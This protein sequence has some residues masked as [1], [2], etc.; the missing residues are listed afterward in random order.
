MNT[1]SARILTRPIDE[2]ALQ[3][4]QQAGVP[5][6]LARLCAARRVL[7]ADELDDALAGLLPHTDLKNCDKAAE[8]LARAVQ[9]RE[10]ILIVADYD[11]DGATACAAGVAGLRAMGGMADFLVP[12]RFEDGYGLTPKI[13]Q[14]AAG[15]GA[16]LLMTVDNGMAGAEGVEKAKSLGMDV[17]ITDHHLPADTD[18]DCIIVNPNQRG[19]GFASKSLAGVGVIFYVLAAL[20]ARLRL[21]G[22]FAGGRTEPN[23]GGLL[24]LVALGT[25]ADVV[26]L[27]RNNRILVAQGLKRIRAGKVCPG[28]LALFEAAGRDWRKAQPLD[29]GFALGPRINAA[30]RLDDMSVGINCLLAQDPGEARRLAAQL[31]NLNSERREIEQ[32]MLQ[33]AL[34]DFSD[35]PADEKKTIVAYRE[36]FHQGVVGIVAGRLK[37][38]FYRPVIVFAPADPGQIRGSGR[39]IPALHL[40]DTL[41]RVAK[42]RPGLILQFGGHAMA[43]G[44]TIRESDLPEFQALFE[45]AADELLEGANLSQSYLTDGNLDA[46]DINLEQARQLSH[47]VWGQG[48]PPPSF[49]DEFTVLHQRG[50]GAEGR[51]KK[52]L[53]EKDGRQFDAMF[54]RCSEE[55]PAKIRAVYRPVANEWR[56]QLELQLHIDYWEAA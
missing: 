32:S 30:G 2:T 55:L 6:L 1:A 21:N 43:A 9:A 13:A 18:P 15:R 23:L 38:R 48:F 51:H 12:N 4:L 8:R 10:N 56:N 39:S 42:R 37:E 17:I 45:Q 46:R 49:N 44:L 41:D 11:A 16:K 14:A 34:D 22:Y 29:M 33:D 36:D 35:T 50:L 5:P 52:A 7:S 40:R 24:D 26:P 25:V 27:D 28:I 54:W 20:R 31:N 3:N 47:Q 53:L 19:C